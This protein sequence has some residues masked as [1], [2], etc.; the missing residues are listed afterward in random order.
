MEA[1]IREKEAEEF[2]FLMGDSDELEKVLPQAA[3]F[4]FSSDWE[5]LPN[6]LVEAMVMGLPVV[7]TDCPCG[8]PAELIRHEE[9]GLL[10]PIGDEDAMTAGICR[11]IEDKELAKRLGTEARK[12]TERTRASVIGDQWEAYLRQVIADWQKRRA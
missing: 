7:A 8:G 3:V 5:G 9:N 6:S 11:L 4:A 1:L 10:V 12:L 2:V